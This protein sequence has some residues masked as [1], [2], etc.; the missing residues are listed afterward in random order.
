ML[1][2]GEK[3]PMKR[4]NG[5]TRQKP[6]GRP[7]PKTKRIDPVKLK[8]IKIAKMI[9]L[10]KKG[11]VTPICC[12]CSKIRISVRDKKG[13]PEKIW[14]DV[15]IKNHEKQDPRFPSYSHTYCEPCAK[16]AAS[17]FKLKK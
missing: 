4:K 14:V 10:A 16:K 15:G 9:K 7:G 3:M 8:K 12:V 6:S 2:L 11:E 5:R 13:N 17:E 1:K